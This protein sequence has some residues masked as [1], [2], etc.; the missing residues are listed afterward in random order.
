MKPL[1][2]FDFKECDDDDSSVIITKTRL[3]EIL[4][5]VYEAGYNDGRLNK[6]NMINYRES[7]LTSRN[8][9]TTSLG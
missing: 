1:I 5:E 3:K 6:T 8:I 7:D 9:N 2:L 4:N